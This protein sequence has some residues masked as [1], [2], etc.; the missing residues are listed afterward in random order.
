MLFLVSQ[1]RISVWGEDCSLRGGTGL[2]FLH[3]LSEGRCRQHISS[4]GLSIDERRERWFLVC[5]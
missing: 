5:P 2:P 3:Q 1:F 4:R